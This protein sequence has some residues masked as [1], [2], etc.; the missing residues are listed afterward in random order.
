MAGRAQPSFPGCSGPLLT[1]T[2]HPVLAGITH[3]QVPAVSLLWATPKRRQSLRGL[4]EGPLARE[5]TGA[6]FTVRFS[7]QRPGKPAD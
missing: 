4:I 1:S 5:R 7:G 2:P 6:T 3:G